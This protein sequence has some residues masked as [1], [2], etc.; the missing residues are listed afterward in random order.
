MK[1][2]LALEVEVFQRMARRRDGAVIY[3]Y[4]R[5]V[6]A[7]PAVDN[8]LHFVLMTFGSVY[9]TLKHRMQHRAVDAAVETL[10]SS[11]VLRE[12]DTTPLVWK[13]ITTA[14]DADLGLVSSEQEVILSIKEIAQLKKGSEKGA[15]Q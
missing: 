10:R 15:E 11:G 14:L 13:L 7:N 12:S 1:L 3:N 4:Q 6:N 2:K 9:P 5:A 8:F